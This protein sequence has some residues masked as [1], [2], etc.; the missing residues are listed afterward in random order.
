[1]SHRL[2]VD[3]LLTLAPYK[4]D[5]L[6]VVDD[7]T[8]YYMQSKYETALAYCQTRGIRHMVYVKW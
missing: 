6:V 2:G 7:D 1:M 3:L 4:V 5:T 8:Q